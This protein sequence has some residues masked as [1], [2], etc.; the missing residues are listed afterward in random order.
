MKRQLTL[1]IFVIK[2]RFNSKTCLISV[3]IRKHQVRVSAK[4]KVE[5]EGK[6][7]LFAMVMTVIL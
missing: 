6:F 1:S 3:S 7:Q 4:A 5:I 2:L